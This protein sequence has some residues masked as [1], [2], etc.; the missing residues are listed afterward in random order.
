[1]AQQPEN[2]V[3]SDDKPLNVPVRVL[4]NRY[5]LKA[6][7]PEISVFGGSVLNESYSSTYSYGARAGL[8]L[9]EYLGVEYTYSGFS[10]SDSTDLK[11]IKNFEYCPVDKPCTEKMYLEPSFTR[12]KS[13]HAGVITF[14]PI[15][16]KISLFSKAILYSDIVFSIGG[17]QVKTDQ[18]SKTAIV[19]GIG[20]RFYFAKSFNVRFDATD[21][22]F[23]ETRINKG[24]SKKSTRHAWV[25]SLGASA[26]LW[27]SQ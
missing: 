14:A 2:K 20:Q 19:G 1:M 7:R 10:A 5:F 11:A 9:T 21:H 3:T 27:E 26:F 8:F 12:L 4:Q 16:S 13:S 22:I 15:Y 17:A 6:L 24:V 23:E 25:V 18:G